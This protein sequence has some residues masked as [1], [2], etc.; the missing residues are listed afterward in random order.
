MALS[1]ANL[2]IFEC[3]DYRSGRKMNCARAGAATLSHLLRQSDAARSGK[4]IQRTGTR[5]ENGLP[6]WCPFIPEGTV[7]S[8][9]GNCR[10]RQASAE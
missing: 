3:C 1:I 6:T 7:Y 4:T 8:V 10:K 9:I 5:Q 2:I